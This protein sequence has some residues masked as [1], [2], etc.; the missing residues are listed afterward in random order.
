M[1]K[2]LQSTLKFALELGVFGYLFLWHFKTANTELRLGY[3]FAEM[4]VIT[5][6]ILWVAFGLQTWE[7]I[8]NEHE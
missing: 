2:K 5:I 6:F 3:Y 1:N 8:I 4:V 7:E